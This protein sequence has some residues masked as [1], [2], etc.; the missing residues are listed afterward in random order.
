MR[1]Y[2]VL[3]EFRSFKGDESL[4]GLLLLLFF[5]HLAEGK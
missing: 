2:G 3:A 1:M 4:R 5:F